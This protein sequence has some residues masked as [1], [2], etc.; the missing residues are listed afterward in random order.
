MITANTQRDWNL[1]ENIGKGVKSMSASHPELGKFLMILD[2]YLN[3]EKLNKESTVVEIIKK[4]TNANKVEVWKFL[5]DDNSTLSGILSGKKDLASGYARAIYHGLTTNEANF[6]KHIE[7]LNEKLKRELAGDLISA[8]FRKRIKRG[9]EPSSCF[10]I[11][12]AIL[13][14][15]DKN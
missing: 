7:N 5:P 4:A 1:L 10:L 6:K 14:D 11:F 8:G 3:E 12:K 9:F 15:I 13:K 2:F